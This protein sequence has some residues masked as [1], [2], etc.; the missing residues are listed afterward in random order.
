MFAQ[1]INFNQSINRS[2][3]TLLYISDREANIVDPARAQ[4]T[5][6]QKAYE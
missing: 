6:L 3:K 5:D 4:D 2:I 1:H